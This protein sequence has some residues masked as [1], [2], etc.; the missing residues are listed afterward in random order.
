MGAAVTD[1][2]PTP[3]SGAHDVIPLYGARWFGVLEQMNMPEPMAMDLPATLR[4]VAEGPDG[5]QTPCSDR[6]P[7]TLRVLW[8][9]GIRL[10]VE[11]AVFIEAIR[12]ATHMV[13]ADDLGQDLAAFPLPHGVAPGDSVR[14]DKGVFAS[15]S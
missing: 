15:T 8:D 1:N 12:P 3:E 13:L 11:R 6:E 14:Y 10:S 2:L 7:V 5:E 4:L 9:N